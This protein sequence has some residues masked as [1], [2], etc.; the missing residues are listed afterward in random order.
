MAHASIEGKTDAICQGV[1]GL[2][3]DVARVKSTYGCSEVDGS[4]L[5]LGFELTSALHK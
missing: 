1:V 2:L 3:S 5:E 4:A